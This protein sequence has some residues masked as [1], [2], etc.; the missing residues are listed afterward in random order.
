MMT[1][2][3]TNSL[4]PRNLEIYDIAFN[5]KFFKIL[6]ENFKLLSTSY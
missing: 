5:N 4:T 3:F 6:N 1:K 2:F